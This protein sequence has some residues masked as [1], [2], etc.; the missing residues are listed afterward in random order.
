VSE[1]LLVT[2]PTNAEIDETVQA[3]IPQVDKFIGSEYMPIK[4]RNTN[5]VKWTEKDKM[6]GKTSVHKRGNDPHIDDRG[7]DERKNGNSG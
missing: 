1:G 6:R 7:G 2:Y 4:P 5:K 3:Y